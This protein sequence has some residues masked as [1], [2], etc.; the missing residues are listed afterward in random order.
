MK[1][2]KVISLLLVLFLLNTMITAFSYDEN[3]ESKENMQIEIEQEAKSMVSGTENP[4]V[5]HKP[6]IPPKTN[7]GISLFSIDHSLSGTVSLPNGFTTDRDLEIFIHAYTPAV[8]ENNRVV[9]TIP[10]KGTKPWDSITI[11]AGDTS[12]SY[13]LNIESG[14]YIVFA[15]LSTGISG[16]LSGYAYFNSNG[17]KNKKEAAEII[18]LDSDVSDKDFSLLT[19]TRTISGTVTLAETAPSGGT[20]ITISAGCYEDGANEYLPSHL[21]VPQGQSSVDFEIGVNKFSNYFLHVSGTDIVGGYYDGTLT[22]QNFYD[23]RSFINTLHD[24]VQNIAIT[25][26]E[27]KTITT[28]VNLRNQVTEDKEFYISYFSSNFNAIANQ[29]ITIKASDEASSFNATMTIDSNYYEQIHIGYADIS[30]FPSIYTDQLN[31]IYKSSLGITT[32]KSKAE[33]IDASLINA[34]TITE[35]E[36]YTVS[37]TADRNNYMENEEIT[38]FAFAEF[39]NGEKYAAH[40]VLQGNINS[41]LIDIN[42]PQYELNNT[43]SLAVAGCERYNKLNDL[44]KNYLENTLTLAGNAQGYSIALNLPPTGDI[45]SVSG[46]FSL[47]SPAPSEGLVVSFNSSYE[48]ISYYI[49]EGQ[50]YVN[51]TIK[52]ALALNPYIS[53]YIHESPDNLLNSSSVLVQGIYE[54]VD[55]SAISA[56]LV[57]GIISVPNGDVLTKAIYGNVYVI[58]EIWLSTQVYIPVGSSSTEYKVK[59]PANSSNLNVFFEQNSNNINELYYSNWLFYH[60]DGA[61]TQ[62]HLAEYFSVETSNKGGINIELFKV[63]SIKGQIHLPQGAYIYGYVHCSIT[64]FNYDYSSY[65]NSNI[66]LDG[67]KS[68]VDYVVSIPFGEDENFNVSF[69][70]NGD[71]YGQTETNIVLER[72]YFYGE[73]GLTLGF[74]NA[75]EINLSEQISVTLNNIYAPLAKAAIKGSVTIP[76]NADLSDSPFLYFEVGASSLNGNT[77]NVNTYIWIEGGET[78]ADFAIYIPME[79]EGDT[80]SLYYNISDNIP[81]LLSGSVYVNENGSFTKNNNNADVYEFSDNKRFDFSFAQESFTKPLARIEAVNL[82]L[83]NEANNAYTINEAESFYV[84]LQ[85][86]DTSEEISL[87]IYIIVYNSNGTINQTRRSSQQSGAEQDHITINESLDFERPEGSYL[88]VMI[89]DGEKQQPLITKIQ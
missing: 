8:D 10:A 77:Y 12:A 4:Q 19:S 46:K 16:V 25:L 54:D 72:Q 75:L 64:V 51:Y 1:K 58:G 38:V 81:G 29:W 17:T 83:N 82:Y 68:V 49:P 21:V 28:T 48:Y 34:V 85:K 62:Q 76:P 6:I 27:G 11:P 26:K 78:S 79:E 40:A 14:K 53:A 33:L 66:V 67:S 69:M 55:F 89:W 59:V 23:N 7:N 71:Y 37:V 13:Q 88:S 80:Y 45:V 44:T 2:N 15:F 5:I 39:E 9:D 60:P 18:N 32:V 22:L 41:K 61:M 30:D 35:P 70:F 20:S 42:I 65:F 3:Y 73:N 57:T 43:F 31:Y 36:F 47:P 87:D 56:V 24:N 84:I 86:A 63:R 52:A 74:D 50:S